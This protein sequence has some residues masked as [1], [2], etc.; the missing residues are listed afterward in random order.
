MENQ[1]Y[2]SYVGGEIPENSFIV[3]S[4]DDE[5]YFSPTE[6]SFFTPKIHEVMPPDAKKISRELYDDLL[7]KINFGYTLECDED[8]NPIAK[9]IEFPKEYTLDYYKIKLVTYFDSVAYSAGFVSMA[10]ALTY[11]D[12][13]DTEKSELAKKLR[14]WRFEVN[15]AFKEMEDQATSIDEKDVQAFFDLLP[16]FPS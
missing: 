2:E 9:K 13:P 11:I 6:K 12:D 5:M 7:T 14:Q 10:D 4:P 8:G 3:S 16:K 15:K 1:I